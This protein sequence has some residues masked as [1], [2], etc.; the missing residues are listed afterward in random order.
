MNTEAFNDD[1]DTIYSQAD[2]HNIN[3]DLIMLLLTMQD[4]ISKL[5]PCT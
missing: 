2:L 4:Y 3:N 5:Y 1:G